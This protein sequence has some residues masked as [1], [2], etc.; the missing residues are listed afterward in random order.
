MICQIENIQHL[1]DTD[2]KT[3][4]KIFQRLWDQIETGILEHKYYYEPS[5]NAKIFSMGDLG[6]I[7]ENRTLT[8]GSPWRTWTGLLLERRLSWAKSLIQSAKQNDIN[9]VNFAYSRHLSYISSHVDGKTTVEKCNEH[10]NLNF[11]VKSDDPNAYTWSCDQ[12]E[13]YHCRPGTAWLLETNS[14]HGVEN[15]G[16]RDIFQIKFHS[17]FLRVKTWLDNNTELLGEINQK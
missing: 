13:K 4:G 10:C 9:F 1:Q 7:S 11:V 6:S 5:Y 12:T 3:I 17:N 16:V 14:I 8:D 15:H 2:W